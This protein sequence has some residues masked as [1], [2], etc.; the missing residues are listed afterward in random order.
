VKVL[1][2]P[3]LLVTA[4]FPPSMAD[5]SPVIGE[6]QPGAAELPGVRGVELVEF[7]EDHRLVLRGKSPARCPL[8][9]KAKVAAS[10]AVTVTRIARL[11]A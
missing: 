5:S 4:M 11:R 7:L 2:S 6:A 1:P 8:R 10:V 9:K 3:G